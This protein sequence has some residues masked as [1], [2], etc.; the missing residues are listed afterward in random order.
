M[1][2]WLIFFTNQSLLPTF[3]YRP[4]IFINFFLPTEIFCRFS[5]FVSQCIKKQKCLKYERIQRPG[6]LSLNSEL[7]MF[8]KKEICKSLCMYILYLMNSTSTCFMRNVVLHIPI[9]KKLLELIFVLRLNYGI[10]TLLFLEILWH[11]SLWERAS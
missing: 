2:R 11:K 6:I 9:F 7:K 10:Q 3:F 4:T 8:Y 1:A 5:L